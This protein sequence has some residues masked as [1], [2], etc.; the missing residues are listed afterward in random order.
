[1]FQ[2]PYTTSLGPESQFARLASLV[3]GNKRHWRKVARMV[4][5]YNTIHITRPGDA[6]SRNRYIVRAMLNTRLPDEVI[7]EIY[8]VYGL[9]SR[10][11][12]LN[13]LGIY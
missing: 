5:K 8:E 3:R 9:T 1:M 10:A 7:N 13:L 11:T 12:R 6:Q 2:I 4:G